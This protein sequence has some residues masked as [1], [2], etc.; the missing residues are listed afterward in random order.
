MELENGVEQFNAYNRFELSPEQT[1]KLEV[2]MRDIFFSTK[3]RPLIN[4]L[5]PE[6]KSRDYISSE[7]KRIMPENVT[8][9][10]LARRIRVFVPGYDHVTH[11]GYKSDDHCIGLA[12][13]YNSSRPHF[14]CEYALVRSKK[15][16]MRYFNEFIPHQRALLTADQRADAD[17]LFTDPLKPQALDTELM[18]L[19][20]LLEEVK[21]ARIKRNGY[22]EGMRGGMSFAFP[23]F[24]SGI[25]LEP[26]RGEELSPPWEHYLQPTRNY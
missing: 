2:A 1:N 4:N 15:R 21:N 14:I 10:L 26:S 20:K 18:E 7:H 23:V 22:K 24:K 5:S 17:Q 25:P 8:E 19:D 16:P 9:P 3:P 13:I 11:Q 6:R 12:M